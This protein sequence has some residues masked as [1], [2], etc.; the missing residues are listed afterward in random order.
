MSTQ[1]ITPCRLLHSYKV[2][3]NTY[4][5]NGPCRFFL[6][7]YNESKLNLPFLN[8][9]KDILVLGVDVIIKKVN[10]IV[11]SLICLVQIQG[12]TSQ[13]YLLK[14]NFEIRQTFD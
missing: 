14:S 1:L 7:T 13:D 6:Q 2:R 3:Y 10:C 11:L 8:L 4:G 5:R 9:L 12:H